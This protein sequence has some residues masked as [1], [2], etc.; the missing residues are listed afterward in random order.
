[1]LA[2]PLSGNVDVGSGS[3]SVIAP[4]GLRFGLPLDRR[5]RLPKVYRSTDHGHVTVRFP[6]RKTL[7]RRLP[8]AVS[9]EESG[10]LLPGSFV[11]G[12]LQIRR[13]TGGGE[14]V[15]CKWTLC[16]AGR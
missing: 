11:R 7:Q 4:I 13:V 10:R 1:M 9:G 16:L 15:V 3:N 14:G 12:P 6:C 8:P 2:R 5:Q